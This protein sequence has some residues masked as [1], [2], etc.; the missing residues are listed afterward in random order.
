MPCNRIVTLPTPETIRRT[1]R[2]MPL[3]HG[4]SEPLRRCLC[5]GSRQAF[6]RFG[7]DGS[8]LCYDGQYLWCRLCGGV[9]PL[10]TQA[11]PTHL[12]WMGL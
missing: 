7:L 8:L 11:I 3:N 5:W 12:L 9:A 2:R 4:Q 10:I 1:I 6:G